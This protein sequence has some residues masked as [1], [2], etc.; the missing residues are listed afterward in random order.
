METADMEAYPNGIMLPKGFVLPEQFT[1]REG[2]LWLWLGGALLVMGLFISVTLL[3]CLES[4]GD[5]LYVLGGA[6]MAAC[7]LLGFWNGWRK[8]LKIFGEH[9]AYV[10]LFGRTKTFAAADIG[11]VNLNHLTLYGKDGKKLSG[12]FDMA[13]DAPLLMKYLLDHQVP[14]KL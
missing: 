11:A 12:G 3:I 9:I 10:D 14:V 7:G 13:V 1:V 8:R 4:A 2:Q 5:L 6:V